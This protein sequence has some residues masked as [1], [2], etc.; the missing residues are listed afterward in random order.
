MGSDGLFVP[1]GVVNLRVLGLHSSINPGHGGGCIRS[2]PFKNHII[3]LGPV[4]SPPQGPDGGLGYNP[5]CL[6]RDLHTEW[7]N[8]TKPSDVVRLFKTC[9]D[10][11]ECFDFDIEGAVGLHTAGHFTVGGV[12]MDAWASPQD[13]VFFLHHANVDRMWSLW[14]GLSPEKRL[15][16][17]YGTQTALNSQFFFFFSILFI[18][19]RLRR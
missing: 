10:S 16:Q 12:M 3:T 7:S 2:G 6:A 18:C 14:Q 4:A 1:H 13:P 17:V 5:R 15:K 8:Y 9:N 11:F 19:F